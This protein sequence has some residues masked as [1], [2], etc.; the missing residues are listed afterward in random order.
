MFSTRLFGWC[1]NRETIKKNLRVYGTQ[2]RGIYLGRLQRKKGT[3]NSLCYLPKDT[4][5]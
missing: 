3:V 2:N 4:V 5:Y 1:K